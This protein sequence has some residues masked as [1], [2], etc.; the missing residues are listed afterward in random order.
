MYF[1]TTNNML[2]CESI[3]TLF[4]REDTEPVCLKLRI[5]SVYD[6]TGTN[7]CS[8]QCVVKLPTAHLLLVYANMNRSD[9]TSFF[10]CLIG[11]V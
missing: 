1:E 8:Y 3:V 4:T 7:A 10:M 5:T 6:T 9:Y 2:Q 11:I